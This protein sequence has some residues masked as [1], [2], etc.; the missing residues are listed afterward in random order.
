MGRTFNRMPVF[1]VYHLDMDRR[2]LLL[3]GYA[4]LVCAQQPSPAAAEIEGVLRDR[5][6]VFYQLMVDKAYRRAE[7]M[8]A[9]ESKDAYYDRPKPD[10]TMFRIISVEIS[11]AG[12]RAKVTIRANARVLIPGAGSQQ[13]ELPLISSWKLESGVWMWFLDRDLLRQTPLGKLSQ[14]QVSRPSSGRSTIPSQLPD[15]KS[16]LNKVTI[17]R[18]AVILQSGGPD[19]RVVISNNLEGSVD[20]SMQAPAIPVKG[21]TVELEKSTISAGGKGEIRFKAAEGV[22]ISTVVRVSVE[23][24]NIVFE[25]RVQTH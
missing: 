23:P 17:D 4:A 25:I 1:R 10:I 5:V 20:L 9:E 3:P 7:A 21:L 14:E 16:V 13:F 22:P 18:T 12:R 8:V 2:L 11:D 6:R 19:Q 24:L 15:A